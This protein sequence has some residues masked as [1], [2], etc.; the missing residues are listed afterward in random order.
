CLFVVGL[1][2]GGSEGGVEVVEWKEEW[3][4]GCCKEWR[5]NR[6]QVNSTFKKNMGEMSTV[7]GLGFLQS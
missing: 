1:S 4:R 5:E 3:G 6:L 7:T 2:G